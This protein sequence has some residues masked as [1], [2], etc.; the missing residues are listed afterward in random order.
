MSETNV[1]QV[2]VAR[3]RR[4]RRHGRGVRTSVGWAVAEICFTYHGESDDQRGFHGEHTLEDNVMIN[5]F[6]EA[7]GATRYETNRIYRKQLPC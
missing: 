7:I 1:S 5:R 3:E 4:C 6:I 2:A